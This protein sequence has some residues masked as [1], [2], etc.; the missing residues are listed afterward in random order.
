MESGLWI[1]NQLFTNF[2]NDKEMCEDKLL[3]DEWTKDIQIEECLLFSEIAAAGLIPN[4]SAIMSRGCLATGEVEFGVAAGEQAN[5]SPG[6]S[7]E[8]NVAKRSS[9]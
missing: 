8:M 4:V 7:I 9:P 3:I 2:S 6:A 1:V 5:K